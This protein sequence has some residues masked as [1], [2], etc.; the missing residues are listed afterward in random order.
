MYITSLFFSSIGLIL[1]TRLSTGATIGIT[2]ALGIYIPLS[3]LLSIF[4]R[5]PEAIPVSRTEA[6]TQIFAEHFQKTI[7]SNPAMK[8]LFPG[9]K[10][11]VEK[12]VETTKSSDIYNKAVST[13]DKDAFEKA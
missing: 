2:I 4:M 11:N 12:L 5:K 10:D 3:G 8:L 1:S 9:M 7:D 13:D 6:Y